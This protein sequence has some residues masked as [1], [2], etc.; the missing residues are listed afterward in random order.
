MQRPEPHFPKPEFEFEVIC[1]TEISG[2]RAKSVRVGRPPNHRQ[3]YH[4]FLIGRPPRHRRLAASPKG[5]LAILTHA[6]Q[7]AFEGKPNF[8]VLQYRT[9]THS[10]IFKRSH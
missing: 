6:P 2:T 1:R 7:S 9:R 4:Q 10:L 3:T 8:A 5:F